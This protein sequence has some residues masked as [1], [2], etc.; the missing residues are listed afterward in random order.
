M[1][2]LLRLNDYHIKSNAFAGAHDP[3]MMWDPVTKKYYSYCTDAYGPELGLPDE[4]GIPVRSSADLVH[5]RYEKCVLSPKAIA[6]GR[7]N[8]ISGHCQ[9]QRSV[10]RRRLRETRTIPLL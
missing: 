5:F 4:I 8:G 6:Q 7:D 10:D 3:S 9:R 2:G 1:E